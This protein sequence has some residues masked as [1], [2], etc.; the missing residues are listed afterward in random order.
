MPRFMRRTCRRDCGFTMVEVMV[1]LIVVSIGLIDMGLMQVR[2]V[3]T[4]SDAYQRSQATWLAYGVLDQMRANPYNLKGYDAASVGYNMPPISDPVNVTSNIL[5][6][7]KDL[8]EWQ[9]N[10]ALVGGRIGLYNAV[11]SITNTTGQTY[12]VTVL[13][14]RKTQTQ[15][16]QFRRV[17][18]TTE[19]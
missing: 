5:R 18:V 19:L 1:V 17:T 16:Q 9:Q 6:T 13:W 4:I 3:S 10:L 2:A 8:F 14:E 12:Q 7:Q 15:E 11:G